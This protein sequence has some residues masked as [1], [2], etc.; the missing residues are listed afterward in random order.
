MA[1]MTT[2]Q[3]GDHHA[4]LQQRLAAWPRCE[5]GS[6]NDAQCAVVALVLVAAVHAEAMATATEHAV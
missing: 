5:S 1:V 4:Q 6:S 2:V 3:R